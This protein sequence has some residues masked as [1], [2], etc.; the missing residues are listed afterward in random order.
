VGAV[1]G[2]FLAAIG[3]DLLVAFG[4][5][6]LPRLDEAQMDGRVLFVTFVATCLTG[7]LFGLAPVLRLAGTD[8][9]A[10]LQTDAAGR[11]SERSV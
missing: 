9:C 7:V 4:P 6:D 3:M 10:S 2:V 11:S 5:D 8:V 1:L